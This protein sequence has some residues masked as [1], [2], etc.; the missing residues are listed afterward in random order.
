MWSKLL[1]LGSVRGAVPSAFSLHSNFPVCGQVAM[2]EAGHS[3]GV[4]RWKGARPV[5]TS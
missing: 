2:A 1:S 5:L 4:G 3:P